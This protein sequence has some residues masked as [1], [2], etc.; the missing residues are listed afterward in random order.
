[1]WQFPWKYKESFIVTL[2]LFLIGVCLELLFPCNVSSIAYPYNVI[3]GLNIVAIFVLLHVYYKQNPVIQWLSS[4]PASVSSICLF[5][6]L[7]LLMGFIPQTEPSLHTKL[8]IGFNHI[9]TTWQYLF[10]ELFF[11]SSLGI[12]TAKR[13]IPFRIRNVDFILNHG[14]LLLVVLGIWLGAGD[15][16]KV[17]L[18]LRENEV[19]WRGVAQDNK[20]Y[21][22]PFA[23]KLQ[24]FSIEDYNP[25]LVFL[26]NSTGVVFDEK[27]HKQQILIEN[28]LQTSYSNWKIKIKTFLPDAILYEKTFLAFN[29]IGSV[30]AA[31]IEAE[32]S[33][34]SKIQGW[35][36]CGNFVSPFVSLRLN[37]EVS[38]AMAKP[39]PRKYSSRI[40]LYITNKTVIDTTIMVNK[41]FSLDGWKLY[42]TGFDETMGKWSK[43]S[44]IQAVSDP[45]LPVVYC[46]FFMMILGAIR[47]FFYRTKLHE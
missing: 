13:T 42:Q 41:P 38:L 37:N 44:I 1:M 8:N 34:K 32:N 15:K 25:S 23:L 29:G 3:V 31:F 6:V 46:G 35:I 36:S 14:G 39:Q 2:V 43:T 30:P 17:S 7:S 47:M 24:K 20:P 19:V 40:S 28:G 11:L 26:N 5:V 45:W 16:K 33:Q 18:Q 9:Q 12:T 4:I 27:S 21:E 22:L 10:A